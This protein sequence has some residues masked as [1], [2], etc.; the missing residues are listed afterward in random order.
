MKIDFFINM[1]Y[2]KIS[3]RPLRF[4]LRALREILGVFIWMI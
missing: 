4:S 3:Q 2:Y 1:K